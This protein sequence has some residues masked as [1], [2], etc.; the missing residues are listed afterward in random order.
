MAEPRVNYAPEPC[1]FCGGSG[2]DRD[3]SHIECDVCKGVG[4]ILVAQPSK[5]CSFCGGSGRDANRSRLKC[6]SCDGTG[7]AYA[8]AP[9]NEYMTYPMTEQERLLREMERELPNIRAKPF[10]RISDD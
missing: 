10:R 3:Y 8:L 5:K 1:G 9:E 7:W 6:K 4:S 2:R